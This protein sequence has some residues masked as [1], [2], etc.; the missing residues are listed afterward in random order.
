MFEE[1]H[2]DQARAVIEEWKPTNPEQDKEFFDRVVPTL[3]G[4][5]ERLLRRSA[6]NRP[7]R[8]EEFI[9]HSLTYLENRLHALKPGDIVPMAR[10]GETVG[11]FVLVRW[12]EAEKRMQIE[13]FYVE[14]KYQS[15]GIGSSLLD[16]AMQH[17]RGVHSSES[18]GVFLTTGENNEGAQRLYKRFGFSISTIP[19]EEEG[20]VRLELDFIQEPKPSVDLSTVPEEIRD[21][22]SEAQ[23]FTVQEWAR[24]T[25][26]WVEFFKTWTI[27]CRKIGQ[28]Q[29]F[30]EVRRGKAELQKVLEEATLDDDTWNLA[31]ALYCLS[32]E[33]LDTV[34][35][36]FEPEVRQKSGYLN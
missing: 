17:S 3:R 24:V 18:K 32:D 25:P 6:P 33:Q 7:E 20:E 19:A 14:Q 13:Q 16:R 34:I 36:T 26:K 8:P 5:K 21:M 1:G 35:S 29:R 4:I 22:V 28:E 30:M 23:R 27:G 11:G 9:Q 31:M 10:I 15:R 12:N 2:P